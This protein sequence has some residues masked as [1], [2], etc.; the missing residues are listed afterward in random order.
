VTVDTIL[1]ASGQ[2]ASVEDGVFRG[3]LL[4]YGRSIDVPGGTLAVDPG[5]AS[6]ATRDPRRVKILWQHDWNAPIGMML[7]LEETESGLLGRGKITTS[8]DIPEASKAL[9]LLREKIVD[10]LSAGFD[11]HK[12]TPS[13]GPGGALHMQHHAI[14]LREI[15]V[16]TFGAAGRAARVHS[17]NS[18]KPEPDVLSEWR[19]KFAVFG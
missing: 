3:T 6:S 5:A 19:R 2:V 11:H 16:V 15:S 7:E 18:A 8:A 17:V 12:Y 13:E 10:E 9:A 4:P 14:K 1:K